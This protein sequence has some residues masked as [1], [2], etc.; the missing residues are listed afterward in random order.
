MTCQ[1]GK[2]YVVEQGDILFDIAQREL[3]DGNRWREIMNPDCSKLTEELIFPGQELCIPDE[4]LN[5]NSPPNQ[6][7]DR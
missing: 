6:E 7:E 1:C 4:A 5:L 2:S 3:G